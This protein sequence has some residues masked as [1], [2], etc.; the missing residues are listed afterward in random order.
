MYSLT[1]LCMSD[2]AA[3]FFH[4]TCPHSHCI[5]YISL[6]VFFIYK[7]KVDITI[8]KEAEQEQDGRKKLQKNN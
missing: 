4:N 3:M 5:N 6:Q 2:C 8:W 7:H 1:G